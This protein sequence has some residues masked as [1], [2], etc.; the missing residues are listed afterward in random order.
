MTKC[1]SCDE[2]KG[3]R[4]CPGLKGSI[5]SICCGTKREKEILCFEACEYLKKGKDYQLNR[6]IVKKISSDLQEE[7]ADVFETDEV[8]AFVMPIER[9]FIIAG[10]K[11]S[12]EGR[13][14]PEGVHQ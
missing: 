10:N 5:C 6:E 7:T 13:V 3:N 2:R 14:L 11:N 4:F 1:K 9:F 12:I 8:A